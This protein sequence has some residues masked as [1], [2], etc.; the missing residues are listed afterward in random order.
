MWC[1]E[2]DCSEE[3]QRGRAGMTWPK[4]TEVVLIG[5]VDGGSFFQDEE[6]WHNFVGGACLSWVRGGGSPRDG[7]VEFS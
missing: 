1:R 3:W 6:W 5:R 2:E 7:R 4:S